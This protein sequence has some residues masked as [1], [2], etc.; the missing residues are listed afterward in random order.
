M[1]VKI[2]L[3]N[4]IAQLEAQKSQQN[5]ELK[6]IK[7]AELKIEFDSYKQQ[8]QQEYDTAVATLKSSLDA[9][10]VEKQVEIDT[11]INT[12]VDMQSTS[13]DVKIAQLQKM[14]DE[15]VAE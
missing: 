9:A 12:Y 1:S 13:L 8:K 4:A 11:K 7:A 5:A 15:E 6:R 10:L 2:V 14:L 3:Q